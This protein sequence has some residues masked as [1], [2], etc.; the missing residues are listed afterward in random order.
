MESMETEPRQGTVRGAAEGK[1]IAIVGDVYRFLATGSETGGSYASFEAIV[2]PGGGPPPHIHRREEEWFWILEG[3]I[4]FW[5]G[6]RKV[7]AGPGTFVNMPVGSRHCFKNETQQTARMLITV[8]PSGLEELFL[9]VGQVLE[10]D[11][12]TIPQPTA[13]EIQRL[14]AAAPKYGVEILVGESNPATD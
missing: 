12:G 1:R 3:E 6:E 9:E 8:T 11:H 5:E 4:S 2:P 13:E 10:D 7:V 14:I